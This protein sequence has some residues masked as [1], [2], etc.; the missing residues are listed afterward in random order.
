MTAAQI[1]SSSSDAGNLVKPV[2][3]KVE[4]S[5]VTI[6]TLGTARGP[7]GRTVQHAGRRHRH[8]RALRRAILTNAHV[9]EGADTVQ[10]T[11][12]TA[13]PIEASVVGADPRSTSPCCRSTTT[14]RAFR[15]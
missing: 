2:L 11:L 3:D 5:V 15:R 12:A 9:V 4:P 7:F 1:A 10:V 6:E 14:C 13:R 8:D